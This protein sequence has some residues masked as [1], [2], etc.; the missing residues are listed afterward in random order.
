MINIEKQDHF[1]HS[2]ESYIIFECL[3]TRVDDTFYSKADNVVL[4]YNALINLI[5]DDLSKP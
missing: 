1:T 4:T 3:L 2:R 5:L